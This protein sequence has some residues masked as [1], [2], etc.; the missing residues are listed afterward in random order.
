MSL[1]PYL[2]TERL[3]LWMPD[4]KSASA[5]A[6]YYRRNAEFLS[7]WDPPR[8]QGFVTESYWRDRLRRN[9]A[10]FVQGCSVR[11]M[12]REKQDPRTVYGSINLTNIIRGAMFA[13]TLG[14]A[15]DR[16]REGR[17]Y[18]TE[19]LAE[20]VRFSFHD[21][22][23]RRLMA[24]FRPENTKSARVLEKL[25]F[26]REGYAKEYLFIDGAWRDHVLCSV[27]NP[28]F[29]FPITMGPK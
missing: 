4:S 21:L 13:G 28:D 17:G 2:E 20:F 11:V 18:M 5:V 24:G 29:H 22:G 3:V 7:P 26:L 16:S 1:L 23:L 8:P 9:A 27:T 12:V 15:L 19:A 10:D 14:Y 25:G 6:D